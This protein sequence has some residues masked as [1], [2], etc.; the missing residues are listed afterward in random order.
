MTAHVLLG[1]IMYMCNMSHKID[2]SLHI[3]PISSELFLPIYQKRDQN[4][5]MDAC[6]LKEGT[7]PHGCGLFMLNWA[8]HEIV[9]SLS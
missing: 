1:V 5:N 4:K 2:A 9:I 3:C 8:E 7:R 6:T